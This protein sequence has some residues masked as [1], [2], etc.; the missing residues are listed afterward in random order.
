MLAMPGASF[1]REASKGLSADSLLQ[2]GV[3][4]IVYGAER[5]NCFWV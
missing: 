2:A 5:R 3:C 1:R 4:A